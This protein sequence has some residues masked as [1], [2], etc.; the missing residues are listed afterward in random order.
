MLYECGRDDE[1]ARVVGRREVR[2]GD[3]ATSATSR[4]RTTSNGR[5]ESLFKKAI[6][7]DPLH[8]VEARNNM[9]QIQRDKARKAGSSEEKK[10]RQPGGEQP[11]HRARARQQQPPGVL[12][13]ARSS[14]TT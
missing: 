10:L 9:A 7:D 5:A 4:G 2:S 13:A 12:D 11:A 1:A 6:D 14:T 8:S 3:H